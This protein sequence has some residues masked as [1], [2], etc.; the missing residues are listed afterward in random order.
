MAALKEE[1]CVDKRSDKES[2]VACVFVCVLLM[3]VP[4]EER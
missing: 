3:L 2:S 1:L 4:E